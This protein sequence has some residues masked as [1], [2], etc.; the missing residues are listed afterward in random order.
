MYAQVSEI[1]HSL[2]LRFRYDKEWVL[3]AH[4]HLK[5]T[6]YLLLPLHKGTKHVK[7]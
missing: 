7:N 1:F 4:N 2:T 5:S 6:I 3:F